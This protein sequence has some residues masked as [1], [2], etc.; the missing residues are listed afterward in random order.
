MFTIYQSI[1]FRSS[2]R[3]HFKADIG[4]AML[5]S[6]PLTTFMDQ[7]SFVESARARIYLR[8]KGLG[9]SKSKCTTTCDELRELNWKLLN[10]TQGYETV[11]E[12]S[13]LLELHPE[14]EMLQPFDLSFADIFTNI[15]CAMC[16]T[17]RRLCLPSQKLK[18]AIL[19][20]G[21]MTREEA[22]Q[23][24]VDVGSRPACCSGD[25]LV[26]ER[27]GKPFQ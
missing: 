12:Y 10:G 21:V 4:K 26:Q 15:F 24:L 3:C 23:F 17:F 16:D 18:V 27:I 8:S 19:E 2:I 20:L 6:G 5:A 25:A 7:V 11:K 9:L 14:S 13:A 1:C 22:S